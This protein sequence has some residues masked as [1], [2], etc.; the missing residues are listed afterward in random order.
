MLMWFWLPVLILAS[1]AACVLLIVWLRPPAVPVA[2]ALDLFRKQRTQ[3]EAQFFHAAASSGKPR[4]LRW[5]RCEW[6]S[7]V[8]LARDKK[9]GQLLALVGVTISFEAIEGGDMEGL[10]AVG[11]LRNAS[12]VFFFDG[13][14]WSTAGRAVFNL[15]PDEAIRHFAGQYEPVAPQ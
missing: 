14:R 13:L 12:A 7:A 11:N 10:A 3:L 4:G 5:T 1:F 8:E 15:N 9:T 6:G 2:I